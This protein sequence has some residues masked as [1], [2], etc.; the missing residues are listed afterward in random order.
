MGTGKVYL[1]G[2]GPGDL[3]LITV[4]GLEAIRSAD[5]I[6]Y[7]RLLNARLLACAK[8]GAEKIFVGKSSVYHT[9]P[10]EEITRLLIHKAKEGKIVTRLKG[11]DPCIFG[12]G[13]EEAEGLAEA[14]VPFEIVPGI[15]SGIAAPLYAGIPLTHRDYNSSF[16]MVTGHERPEKKESDIDWEKL[17]TATGTLIFYMGVKNLPFIVEQLVRYGRPPETPVALIRWGTYTKQETLVGTL[18]DIVEKVRKQRFKPPAIVIVG[19]VVR[20]RDKLSWFEK[21]PLFGKR[22]VVTR[23]RSQASE[24][25]E[26][27]EELGGEALEFPLINIVPP[28]DT[29]ELDRALRRLGEFDWIVFTSANGVRF[30]FER[31]RALKVDIRTMHKARLLAV[32]PKTAEALEE[33][34][35]VVS[36]IPQD[37]TAEALFGEWKEEFRP[38][39]TVLL[40]RAN[41]AREALPRALREKGLNVTDVVAYETVTAEE[42]KDELVRLL[43]EKK[44]D[45]V[46]FTS[47]STVKNFIRLLAGEDVEA[48]M[49]GVK[50]AC[51]GPV[52]ARTA[53]EAGLPVDAVAKESTIEGLVETLLRL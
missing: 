37:F 52:T 8:P 28:S 5:V 38:G 20:L 31:M 4:K 48:L 18:H 21:K 16:A 25:A 49:R 45:I 41:I 7:D 14:G 44:V 33:K 15:T 13:G 35:L 51:I 34:G 47:S 40:P 36:G 53:E 32:G 19:E 6:V 23:A 43:R 39:Q 50:T 12:R 3:K 22:I 11:G 26:K 27:I 10:Q 17:A 9:L 24:L 30:F 1:V 29:Q 42:G 2:A 46:T